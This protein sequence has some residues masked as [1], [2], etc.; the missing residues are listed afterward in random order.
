MSESRRKRFRSVGPHGTLTV[1]EGD[2]G[3]EASDR[4]VTIAET[5]ITNQN[6]DEFIRLSKEDV[7]TLTTAASVY[8]NGK[9]S[10]SEFIGDCSRRQR[11]IP[12]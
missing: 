8:L 4:R 10:R 3:D 1:A 5:P 2:E 9:L 12:E 11:S 7:A 6:M